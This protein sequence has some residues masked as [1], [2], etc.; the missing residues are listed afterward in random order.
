MIRDVSPYYQN[1][2]QLKTITN[3]TNNHIPDIKL[4][5]YRNSSSDQRRCNRPR[6]AEI[7]AVFVGNNGEPPTKRDLTIYPK[8]STSTTTT[9]TTHDTQTLNIL[10]HHCD[11]MVYPLLFPKGDFG[12]SRGIPLQKIQSL[13]QSDNNQQ[14]LQNNN[15][16]INI[17]LK[18]NNE[19]RTQNNNNENRLQEK[20]NEETPQDDEQEEKKRNGFI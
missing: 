9:T 8:F 4:M 12:W 2:H 10:S 18:D 5:F 6:A 1:F 15:N 20:N 7:A 16:N 13:S 3:S 19:E 14:T 11:P 17:L